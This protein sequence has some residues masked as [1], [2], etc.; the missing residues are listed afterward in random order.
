MRIRY[1]FAAQ[2]MIL[3]AS[4]AP[5]AMEG[6]SPA[7]GDPEFVVN[8][9]LHPSMYTAIPDPARPAG[10]EQVVRHQAETQ[11]AV[12]RESEA[13][14]SGGPKNAKT[15][16]APPRPADAHWP[17]PVRD[18]W[19][20]YRQARLAADQFDIASRRLS[21]TE[22]GRRVADEAWWQA[23]IADHDAEVAYEH[24]CAVWEEWQIGPE[25]SAAPEEPEAGS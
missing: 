5:W 1:L 8:R 16:K 17:E 9:W 3:V 22:P 21:A 23:D 18:A 15:V 13:A 11:W 24:Y 20:Y 6:K 14:T 2:D 25:I 12:I 4:S 7:P 19:E 10:H